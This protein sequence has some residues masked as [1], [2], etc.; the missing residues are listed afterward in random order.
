MAYLFVDPAT[1]C[2]IA[3]GAPENFV[4]FEH[5]LKTKDD[6]TLASRLARIRDKLEGMHADE[7]ITL[8]GYEE[9]RFLKS[10][11]AA[12]CHGAIVG[13]ILLFARDH[14][15]PVVTVPVATL[16]KYWT[17][18]GNASKQDMVD[19]AFSIAGVELTH[20]AADALAGLYW[21]HD[22]YP[23]EQPAPVIEGGCYPQA[24]E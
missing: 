17:D 8:I 3:M 14:N 15:I 10:A 22:T 18:K 6:A 23:I 1:V 4:A 2:G 12:H 5:N 24:A 9:S 16:K 19:A 21:M 11:D 13:V 20:N 7:P